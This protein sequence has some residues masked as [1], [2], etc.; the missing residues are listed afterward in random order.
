M[1]YLS[2]EGRLRKVANAF[3]IGKSSASRI[4]RRV[5]QSI[6]KFLATNYIQAPTIGEGVNNLVKNFYK[7]RG[8]PQCLGIKIRTKQPSFSARWDYQEY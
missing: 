4:I 5:T 7:Q 8:F 1:Y 2:D 3:G 6:S